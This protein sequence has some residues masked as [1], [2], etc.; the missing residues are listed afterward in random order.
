MYAALW[1][2]ALLPRVVYIALAHPSAESHY[3]LLASGLLRDGTLAIDRVPTT[4]FEPLYPM[5]LTTARWM[6]GDRVV[7]VQ[8]LQAAVAAAAVI[9]LC[10]LASTLT[11][12]MRVGVIAAALYAAY[13]LLI[14][15][16]ADA[17]ETALLTALLLAFCAAFVR[18]TT[19]GRTA[20]AGVWLGLAALTR[21]VTW[22]LLAIAPLLMIRRGIDRAA[23][24][25]LTALV[26]VSPYAIRNYALNGSW[27]PTR[28]GG[29][30]FVSNSEYSLSLMP[31]HAPDVLGPYTETLLEREGLSRG[32]DS[33]AVDREEDAM[34]RRLTRDAVRKRPLAVLW[35]K[36]RNL[37]YFFSP[38]LVPYYEPTPDTRVT[39][40]PDGAMRVD[41]SRPRPLA[42]QLAYSVPYVIVVGC[43]L[44]GIYVRRRDL[45][46]D[47]ILW[48]LVVTFAVTYAIFFPTTRYRAPIEFVLLFY[49]AVGLDACWLGTRTSTV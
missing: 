23:A 12:R 18:A 5:F 25:A 43:A 19:I 16:S 27:A 37:W 1:A 7:V 14:R 17:T 41:G 22:P 39:L 8:V 47:V 48:S 44:G 21:A 35:L 3:W 4:A 31:E 38:R 34:F 46:A 30:L 26:I 24:L 33:P 28:A 13:P 15:H 20:V 6:T 11:G 40:G 2:A 9:P 49:A 10:A 42:F 32:P 36:V 45:A 29:N